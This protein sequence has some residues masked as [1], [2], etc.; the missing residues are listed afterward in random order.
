MARDHGFHPVRITRVVDETP[1]TRTFALDA[2]FPYLAGQFLT[3]KVCGTLRSYSMSSS[4]DTDEEVC[5]TVKRVP[6]GLVS[7]WMHERL[8]P[9]DTLEAALPGG[10]FCLREDA[11]DRPLVAYAGG[12]GI[13]PVYS[14]VKS[15]LA[16]TRRDVRLLTAHQNAGAAIFRP[17]LDALAARHP[18]RLGLRHHFD[19]RDGLVTE[20]EIRALADEGADFYVCGPEPFMA[21]V[22]RTLAAHR[23]PPERILIERFTPAAPEA[24]PQETPPAPQGPLAGTVTVGLRG[25]RRTVPQRPGETL[26]QSARRAGFTPP[27]S[28]ESGDCA[29][30]MA[31]LTGGEAKMRANNALDADEVAE[32]YVLT[33]QAEPTTPEVTVLYED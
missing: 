26:L 3:F 22:E 21:L 17:A 28:C 33:C 11:A 20:E 25:Q 19:D 7:G 6:G 23:V 32:G 27:F 10:S 5:V 4:P 24:T 12:S 29:T 31:R 30:C 2:H 8:R 9:G 16:T 15:A 14:L 1:D 18:G 13:T